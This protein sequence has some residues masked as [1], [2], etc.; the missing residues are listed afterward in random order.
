MFIPLGDDNSA[1]VLVPYVNWT[2]IVVNVLAFLVELSVQGQGTLP[3]FLNHW[4]VIAADY[5]RHSRSER[6]AF[7]GAH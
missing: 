5:T 7:G 2:L 6:A 1:R 3:A 4:S